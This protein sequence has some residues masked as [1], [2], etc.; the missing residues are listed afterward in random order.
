MLTLPAGAA[1]FPGQFVHSFADKPE[2]VSGPQR[3]QLDSSLPPFEENLPGWQF[4]HALAAVSAL[5]VPGGQLVHLLAPW[6]AANIPLEQISQVEMAVAPS[7]TEYLPA[8]QL[9][10]VLEP[11]AV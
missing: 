11:A 5:Y 1:A 10:H 2:Y 3:M 7:S 6:V 9:E 8:A 4:E